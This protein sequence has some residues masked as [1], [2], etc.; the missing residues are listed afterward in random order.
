M[1]GCAPLKKM[2][3]RYIRIGM[4]LLFLILLN[5]GNNTNLIDA[6][7]S[8]NQL[9]LTEVFPD[10]TDV[11][12]GESVFFTVHVT[13]NS[14]PV[15]TGI[16]TVHEETDS[17]YEVSGN[18]SDGVAILGWVA[19]SSTPTGWCTFIA[20][21]EGTTGYDPSSDTTQVSVAN[22]VI[23]GEDE[24]RTTITPN[25]TTVYPNDTVNFDIII[26]GSAPFFGGYIALYD[27]TEN[28]VLQRHDIILTMAA[29]YSTSMDLTIPSWYVN[30]SHTIE[31]RYTGSYDIYHAP[32]SDS[33]IIQAITQTTPPL[34]ENYTILMVIRNLRLRY[35]RA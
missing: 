16:V 20:D 33:C 3:K 24:T 23:P 26:T 29:T 35:L 5:M 17:I 4:S 9:T 34:N 25:V 19:Q 11:D 10:R 32:S 7:P 27:I 15:P 12:V 1:H 18:V 31:A 8:G 2:Q 30:G 22:P 6:S 21:Y 28:I 14:E 13:A